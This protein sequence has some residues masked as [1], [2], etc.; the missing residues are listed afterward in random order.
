M[1]GDERVSWRIGP[2]KPRC[3]R[4]FAYRWPTPIP[5]SLAEVLRNPHPRT[6][7]LQTPIQKLDQLLPWNWRP[8]D[9]AITA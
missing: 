3:R 2:I 1:T 6:R 7:T 9:Q 8:Q 4:A 5:E